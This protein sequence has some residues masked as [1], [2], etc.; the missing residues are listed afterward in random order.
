[1]TRGV[2]ETGTILDRILLRTAADLAERRVRCPID[3]LEHQ[4][5]ATPVRASLR[6]GIARSGM[7]VIAE[8]KRASPSKGRFPVEIDPADVAAE[9]VAGGAIGISV[10]TD[11]PFFQG[12]LTDLSAAAIVA[13][14]ASPPVA[15]L[16]KDFV[17]D[18]YQILEARAA[19]ADA[20]L[21]IVAALDQALLGRLLNFATKI[22]LEALVE[23]HTAEEMDRAANV[24]AEVIGINNRDLHTFTVDLTTS[25]RL[26]RMRPA[27]S[28]IV[29]ESGIASRQDAERLEAAGVDG[30]LVGESLVLS[31]DRAAA[32]QELRGV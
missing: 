30:I 2:V 32:I 17:I 5:M 8:F 25:E 31:A 7:S 15:I 6:D 13:H 12:T 29:A 24:G 10:L 28:Q 4:A 14:E 9:F 16:R 3:V 19:G 20:I 26:A 18:E 11:E 1:V 27:G 21:L 22:G 23:A